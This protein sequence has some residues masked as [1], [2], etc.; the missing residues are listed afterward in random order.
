MERHENNCWRFA[1]IRVILPRPVI[2]DDWRH[3]HRRG[4]GERCRDVVECRSLFRGNR[5]DKRA[6]QFASRQ[7]NVFP[8]QV[9][10]RR[11]LFNYFLHLHLHIHLTNHRR[12]TLRNHLHR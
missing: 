8:I 12:S 5:A 1:S 6:E 10:E 9:R 7:K 11:D 4:D 3:G 2:H